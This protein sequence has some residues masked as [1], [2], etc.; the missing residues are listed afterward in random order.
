VSFQ[1]SEVSYQFSAFSFQHG[2]PGNSARPAL[3]RGE[4]ENPET[5]ADPRLWRDGGNRVLAGNVAGR[6]SRKAAGMAWG[7]P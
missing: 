6:A 1:L 5:P 3:G 2:S 7:E 4:N